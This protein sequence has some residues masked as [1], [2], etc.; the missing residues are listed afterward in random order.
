MA[1]FYLDNIYFVDRDAEVESA[2]VFTISMILKIF[3]H[4]QWLNIK[5]HDSIL[6]TTLI[7]HD[8]L[9]RKVQELEIREKETTL[10]LTYKRS[11]DF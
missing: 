8:L 6:N 4:D 10:K 7:I 5:G 1:P 2:F 11:A 9:G 3:A